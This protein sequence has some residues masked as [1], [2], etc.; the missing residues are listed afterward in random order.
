MD[1]GS[2]SGTNSCCLGPTVQP[3][4]PLSIDVCQTLPA[5]PSHSASTPFPY[6]ASYLTTATPTESSDFE[7]SFPTGL[8]TTISRSFTPTQFSTTSSAL[9]TYSDT[10]DPAYPALITSSSPA[11]G[12]SGSASQNPGILHT[13]DPLLLDIYH[14]SGTS[15]ASFTDTDSSTSFMLDHSMASC[16][17]EGDNIV[18]SDP[19]APTLAE[20][21]ALDHS[22]FEPVDYQP[23]VDYY[24][25][26]HYSDQG[27]AFS[28]DV[29]NPDP[30]VFQHLLTQLKASIMSPFFGWTPAT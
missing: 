4:N 12:Y 6:A 3:S 17:P 7:L 22:S 29:S 11:S 30:L 2:S 25:S 27:S 16:F 19:Y 8:P 15:F 9:P 10:F 18:H 23:S 13:L 1:M 5:I 26:T 21:A 20:F 28:P 14:T 24:E